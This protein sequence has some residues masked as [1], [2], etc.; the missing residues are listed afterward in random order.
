MAAPP[1]RNTSVFIRFGALPT[2][3]T[4][5]CF[6][7]FASITLTESSSELETKSRSLS[8]VNAIQFGLA[9]IGG[10]QVTEEELSALLLDTTRI[11][12]ECGFPDDR[13]EESR[14]RFDRRLAGFLHRRMAITPNQAADEEIWSYLSVGPLAAFAAWR[15]D[16]GTRASF[17][18][19]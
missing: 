17:R 6:I 13:R 4:A 1:Y 16:L 18:L 9:P 3:T 19:P 5:T 10:R 7:G 8:G 11:A 15:L 2:G 14:L 12:T